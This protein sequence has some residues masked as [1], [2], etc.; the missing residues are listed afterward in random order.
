MRWIHY[1][2]N[3]ICEWLLLWL[4]CMIDYCDDC[5]IIVVLCTINIHECILTPVYLCVVSLCMWCRYSSRGTL[6]VSCVGGWH[7]SLLFYLSFFS[8]VVSTCR[9]DSVTLWWEYHFLF[10]VLQVV[11]LFI[12]W[13]KMK[14]ISI[15]WDN[16]WS[17]VE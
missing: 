2:H 5:T 14:L 13:F 7:N 12:L 3:N 9:S 16:Q 10:C 4:D 8:C 1:I 11:E 15:L 6:D 17:C